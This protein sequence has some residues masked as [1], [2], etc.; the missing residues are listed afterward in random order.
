M[1]IVRRG[2]ATK[3]EHDV[4]RRLDVMPIV[5]RGRATKVEHDVV[6][7]LDG[8][9]TKRCGYVLVSGKFVELRHVSFG[10]IHINHE[11][12]G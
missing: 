3:V 7:R 2:R 5:R 8:R 9:L 10:D 6:R 4:I 12:L 1:T 11:I